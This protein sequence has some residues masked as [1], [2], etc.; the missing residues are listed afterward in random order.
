[1]RAV[2]D[3]CASTLFGYKAGCNMQQLSPRVACMYPCVLQRGIEQP[4]KMVHDHMRCIIFA[5]T[6]AA[7]SRTPTTNTVLSAKPRRDR[8]NCK[9][10]TIR[11]LGHFVPGTTNAYVHVET[12]ALQ[13]KPTST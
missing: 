7:H 13:N 5:A 12:H 1:M 4:L 10:L 3:G 9:G 11:S 2:D 6:R 8:D